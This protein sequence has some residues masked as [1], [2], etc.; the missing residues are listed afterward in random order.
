MQFTTVILAAVSLALSAS[1][2]PAPSPATGLA[3]RQFEGTHTGQGTYFEVGLG[4]CG[5]QNS[6]ADFIAAVSESF[7]DTYPGATPNPNNNPVCQR[8]ITAQYQGRSVTVAVADRC[9]ACA[10]YDLDFSPAAFTQ[11]AGSL[12][13][14][15]ISGMTWELL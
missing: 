5:R 3:T 13:V 7:F 6:D 2:I 11:L 12:S 1:A 15:R 8:R 4:A 14:G 10:L 9:E